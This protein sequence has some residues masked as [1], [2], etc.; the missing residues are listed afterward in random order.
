MLLIASIF[1]IN[2]VVEFYIFRAVHLRKILAGKPTWRT[3]SSVICLFESSKCF[4]LDLHTG[5]PLT[6]IDY[7]RCCINAVVLS[8]DEDSNKRIIEDFK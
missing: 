1:R 2:V 7:T 3:I 8:E 5:R 4:H 6:Q